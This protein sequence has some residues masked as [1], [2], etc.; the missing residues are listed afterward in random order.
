MR[1]I[2][3]TV[4]FLFCSS[5]LLFPK[6]SLVFIRL[7]NE[8]EYNRFASFGYDL[9]SASRSKD[10]I[11]IVLNSQEIGFLDEQ[12]FKYKVIVDDYETYLSNKI[13]SEYEKWKYPK[14]L[15]FSLGSMSGFYK[16]NEI[17]QQ[18]DLM[19]GSYPQ[20]FI[21]KDTIGY[22]WENRPILAYSFGNP[23]ANVPKI[24]ITCL[25]HSRE[26]GTVTTVV[27]FL[28][29]MFELGQLGDPE[30]LF[31]LSNRQIWVIPVLNPDGYVYN[32][33]HYPNG[34]GLWRKNRR[35][36]NDSTFGVDLNRNY[37]PFE[38]WNADNNGSS[39]RP[40]MET[41]RGDAPFSEPETRAIRSFCMQHNF[42]LALNFHT[43][44]GMLIY[45]FVAIERETPDSNFYRGFSKYINSFNG[46]YFG[47]DKETVGYPTRGNSDDWMYADDSLKGKIVAMTPEAGYQFDGFWPNPNRIVPIAIEN[48]PLLRNWLWSAEAN[49]RPTDFI[50]RFDTLRKIGSI[51]I[52]LQ[53]IGLSD[54]NISFPLRITSLSNEYPFDSTITISGLESA[55]DTSF[56]IQLPIPK[57]NFVN[58]T[59]INFNVEI[60]QNGISR[61]DTFGVTLYD[62]KIV[63]LMERQWWDFSKGIWDFELDQISGR[64]IL[65]DS[66]HR[67]YLDSTEDI[68]LLR[69]PFQLNYNNAQLAILSQWQIEPFYDF[70]TVEISTDGGS[71][72]INI[73][74]KLST[75]ASGNQSGKQKLGTF[76]FAGIF[77]YQNLQLFDLKPYLSKN[78]LLKFTL[79]SDRAKNYSGWDISELQFRLYPTINF[80]NYQSN[81]DLKHDLLKIR[82]PNSAV[83]TLELPSNF[84]L[85]YYKIYNILGV[86]V[87]ETYPVSNDLI[88]IP[89][90]PGGVYLLQLVGRNNITEFRK[91]IV[92]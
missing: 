77:P 32:E 85:K 75:P 47:Q 59:E 9:E 54:Y 15:G 6:Y 25:H 7:N 73:R 63:D 11:T 76:G 52:S 70:A 44:G 50:Y 61:N 12:K 91:I 49:I 90:L 56:T 69:Q 14:P 46:Y 8:V 41:Y 60:V 19:E 10:G 74:S 83:E 64:Y 81:Y 48:F 38:F 42:K 23:S 84:N 87:F 79:L 13:A 67:N 30:A 68:L 29:R 40:Q 21:S 17:Y 51:K 37:G 88:E 57:P 33:T 2:L 45:P 55:Q 4:I 31:L 89:K 43:Y 1:K 20:F 34:G 62:Y 36:L 86:N 39:T 22:S 80:G 35:K 72:W 66:P 65:S 92:R 24:L 18:F 53:N 82:Y 71:K 58:G 27:F 26:P 16:L 78:I 5:S 3:I 28:F